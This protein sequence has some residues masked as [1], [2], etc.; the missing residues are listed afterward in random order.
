MTVTVAPGPARRTAALDVR[1]VRAS[2]FAT[3]SVALAAAAHGAAGGAA[4]GLPLVALGWLL[5][6]AA[7][8]VAAGRRRSLPAI[9]AGVAAGQLGLHLLFRTGHTMTTPLPT[10]ASMPGMPGM[11]AGAHRPGGRT[12]SG[13]VPSAGTGPH[14]GHLHHTAAVVH[15]GV[16]GLSPGMLAGHAAAALATG[17]LLHRVEVA[18]W[19]LLDLT[20]TVRAAARHWSR[21]V[22]R[23]LAV[24]TGTAV[25]PAAPLVRTWLRRDTVPPHHRSALLRHS[26]LRRGPPGVVTA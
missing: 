19:R 18:L 5:V 22:R 9:T 3:V 14:A 10:P 15:A 21:R 20:R 11:P 1:L 24:L 16:L 6:C 13:P 26:L 7:A 8:G 17:W 12:G 4:V 25:P 23:T 2:A